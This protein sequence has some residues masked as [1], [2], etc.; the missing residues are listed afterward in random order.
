[1]PAFAPH[2]LLPPHWEPSQLVALQA[3]NSAGHGAGPGTPACLLQLA[4]GEP[5]A[6]AGRGRQEHGSGS[7]LPAGNGNTELSEKPDVV[8]HCLEL[9]M[10]MPPGMGSARLPKVHVGGHFPA[11]A[12]EMSLCSSQLGAPAKSFGQP[13]HAE[14][15]C[16]LPAPAQQEA[17]TVAGFPPEPQ[18]AP[19]WSRWSSMSMPTGIGPG[20]VGAAVT[21]PQWLCPCLA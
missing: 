15:S 1:M 5:G 21:I 13:R 17:W 7:S 3:R 19:E 10:G 9:G 20:A 11:E 14:S 8:R 2:Q 4:R 12:G 6:A 16:L 18:A